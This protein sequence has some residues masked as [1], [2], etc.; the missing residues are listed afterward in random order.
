L[1]WDVC[2]G[3]IRSACMAHKTGSSGYFNLVLMP[4]KRVK[5]SEVS[6][7]EMIFVIDRSGSQE[8]APLEKAKETMNYIL[9]NMNPQD[10]FQVLSFSN[11]AET[12]FDKPQAASESMKKKAHAYVNSLEANGG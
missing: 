6:P 1:S 9:D 8:G 7:K 4:P 3:A 11:E 5:Q 12:L 10:T 2:D